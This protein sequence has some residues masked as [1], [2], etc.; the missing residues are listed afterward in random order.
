[1]CGGLHSI[2]YLKIDFIKKEK[3]YEKS[4]NCVRYTLLPYR[5]VLLDALMETHS[6]DAYLLSLETA[7]E[8][9]DELINFFEEDAE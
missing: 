6:D 5:L 2:P 4:F 7:D 9:I 8:N 1:M 3:R